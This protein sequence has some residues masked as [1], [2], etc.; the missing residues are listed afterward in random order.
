MRSICSPRR[1]RISP[2]ASAQAR[3]DDD[4]TSLHDDDA[5]WA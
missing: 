3:S 1:S 2:E 5:F 4:F